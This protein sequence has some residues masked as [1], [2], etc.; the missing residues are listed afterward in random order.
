MS[1]E[2]VAK[3][4]ADLQ[5]AP[6]Q[7]EMMRVLRERMIETKVLTSENLAFFDYKPIYYKFSQA[8]GWN[9]DKA[10]LMMANHVEWRTKNNLSTTV[11]TA[12]GPIPAHCVQYRYPEHEAIKKA[13]NFT[14]HKTAK[15]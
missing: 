10:Y 3:W 5:F 6:E 7:N 13:Y 9:L 8:R 11:P 15:N 12:V 14:H 1:P 4:E 2:R